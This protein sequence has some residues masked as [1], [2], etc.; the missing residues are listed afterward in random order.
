MFTQPLSM[1]CTKE[2]YEKYLREPLRKLGYKETALSMYEEDWGG[3]LVT[4]YSSQHNW[5]TCMVR[6]RDNEFNNGRRDLGSFNAPLFLALAAMTDIPYGIE[7]EY[8]TFV[9][10]LQIS[11]TENKIY[12][13][14]DFWEDGTPILVDDTGVRNGYNLSTFFKMF[15]KSTRE[16][17]LTSFGKEVPPVKSRVQSDEELISILK[18]RGYRIF[19]ETT[20]LKEV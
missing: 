12:K 18:A 6:D 14:I 20:E 9:E 4:N 15:R 16:E 10:P 5:A 19:K 17:I 7:G 11:F 13:C 8:W 2:Q 3:L 1:D